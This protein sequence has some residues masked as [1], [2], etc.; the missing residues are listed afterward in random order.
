MAADNKNNTNKRGPG[1]PPGSKNKKTSG[2]SSGN[3]A[4]PASDPSQVKYDRIREMQE[5]YDRERRNLDVIWSITLAALGLFLL[6]TVVMNST[7]TPT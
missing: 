4:K 7:G 2:S 3:G 1:R 6:F 5:E